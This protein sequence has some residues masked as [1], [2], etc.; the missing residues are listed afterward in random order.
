MNGVSIAKLVDA[1]P[2]LYHVTSEGSWP[3]IEKHGLLS[4]EAL[5]DLFEIS[6]AQRDQLLMSRRPEGVTITHPV[7]GRAIIRDQKPLI[8]SRLRTALEDGL[9]PTDWYELLNR[10]TFFWVSPDRVETL[11]NARAYETLRQTLIEVDTARLLDR[12]AEKV[13]LCPMN[14]GA[15]RPMAFPRGKQTFLPINEYAFEERRRKRGLKHAVVELTVDYVVKDIREL[16][17]CV[18]ELGGGSPETI[19]FS[20]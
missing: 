18:R 7:H 15:T 11:R 12:H 19:L 8:E 16:V 9:Q 10:R 1:Y 3:F 20:R 2:R 4:T 14:S 17:V 5:L 6:G 13:N